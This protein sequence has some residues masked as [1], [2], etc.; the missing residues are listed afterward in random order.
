MSAEDLF[1][2]FDRAVESDYP[3]LMPD[4]DA[5]PSPPLRPTL[6][7]LQVLISKFQARIRIPERRN[8][9]LELKVDELQE[10]FH[11]LKNII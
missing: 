1:A 9:R 11:K 2:E 5:V 7:E 3:S 6:A 8:D 10:D 4:A